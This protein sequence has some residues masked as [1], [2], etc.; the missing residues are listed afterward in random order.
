[1]II[2]MVQKNEERES[3]RWYGKA[4]KCLIRDKVP[5]VF[6]RILKRDSTLFLQI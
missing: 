2:I 1:M 4:P 6:K 5:G 3:N